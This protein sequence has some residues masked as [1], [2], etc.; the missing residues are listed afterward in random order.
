MAQEQVQKQKQQAK[1]EEAA[2]EEVKNVQN[3][4]LTGSTEDTLAA[5][6]DVLDAQVDEELLADIDDLLEVN[7]EEFVSQY[8]QQGGE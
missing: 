7:A 6:D 4:E 2:A 5:I 1:T 8:V 3:D